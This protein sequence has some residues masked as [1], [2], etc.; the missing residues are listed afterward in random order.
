MNELK[1][2]IFAVMYH[3]SAYFYILVIVVSSVLP[4]IGEFFCDIYPTFYTIN[5]KSIFNIV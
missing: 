2:C 5:G 1:T 4:K 3:I